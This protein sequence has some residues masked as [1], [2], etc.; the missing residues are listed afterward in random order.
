MGSPRRDRLALARARSAGGQPGPAPGAA[1]AFLVPAIEPIRATLSAALGKEL[2]VV[3]LGGNFNLPGSTDQ[4]FH[5]DADDGA[6]RLV[7]NVGLVEGDL[8]NGPTEI[9]RESAG[10]DSY[11]RFLREGWLRRAEAA[12]LGPGDVL[13][14]RAQLW[15]R[16]TA[17][18]SSRA[19]PMAGLVLVER[20]VADKVAIVDGSIAFAGNRFYGRFA[21]LKERI[22]VHAPW[23][24]DA[25]RRLRS[26]LGDG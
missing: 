12:V 14:R 2:A 24:A 23:L 5:R 22:A 10:I 9:V 15:H 17:N 20:A 7:V 8:A 16:G 4:D 3:Q 26:S 6:A 11:R 19:R 1:G 13:I 25:L 18:R 21:R